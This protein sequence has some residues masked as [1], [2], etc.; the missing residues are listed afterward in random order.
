MLDILASEIAN[1]GF[2]S[3]LVSASGKFLKLVKFLFFCTHFPLIYDYL[4]KSHIFFVRSKRNI[5]LSWLYKAADFE[6]AAVQYEDKHWK[7][8]RNFG[9]CQLDQDVAQHQAN[10]LETEQKLDAMKGM[11]RL[12]VFLIDVFM[13]HHCSLW[14]DLPHQVLTAMM[15]FSLVCWPFMV[16]VGWPSGGA[17][18]VPTTTWISWIHIWICPIARPAGT[19]WVL[20][21]WYLFWATLLRDRCSLVSCSMNFI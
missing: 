21:D 9:H 14:L 11:G 5:Q 6:V 17:L 10:R 15:C 2:P 8:Y 19:F 4:R 16:T 18:Y 13:I 12:C 7:C 20:M 1:S 3:I